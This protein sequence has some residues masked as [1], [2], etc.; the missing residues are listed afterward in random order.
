MREE[1]LLE[2]M[3]RTNFPCFDGITLYRAAVRHARK[4]DEC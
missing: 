2:T 4:T 3:N 1:I